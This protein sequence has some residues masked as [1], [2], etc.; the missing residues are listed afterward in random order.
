MVKLWRASVRTNLPSM[1]LWGWSDQQIMSSDISEQN[2][3]FC[4]FEAL[5]AWGQIASGKVLLLSTSTSGAW[6][7]ITS[8]PTLSA[9]IQKKTH[10]FRFQKKKKHLI[11]ICITSFIKRAKLLH[12]F[13]GYLCFFFIN[14]LS[15]LSAFKLIFS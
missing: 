5:V 9:I 12:I 7:L 3:T 11:Y 1:N 8:L 10:L 2:Y 14:C 4:L 15:S 13:A 6:E